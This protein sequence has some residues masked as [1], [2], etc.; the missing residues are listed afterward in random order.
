[1]RWSLFL[2]NQGICISTLSKF[3]P[4]SKGIL[5]R[6]WKR[7]RISGLRNALQ[8][9]NKY[10]FREKYLIQTY[11]VVDFTETGHFDLEKATRQLLLSPESP[12]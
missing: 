12:S 7:T 3:A 6:F 4:I 10:F 8:K 2:P 1:M 11:R 9:A 5:E